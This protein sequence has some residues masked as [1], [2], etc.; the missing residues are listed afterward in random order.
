MTKKNIWI[1]TEERPKNKVLE[2]ILNKFVH[3]RK[4]TAFIDNL[5]ILP[6]FDLENL[7][8]LIN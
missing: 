8:L 3:D 6:I 7:Y 1:L 5:R 4:F 2:I